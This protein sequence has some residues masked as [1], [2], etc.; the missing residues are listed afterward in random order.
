MFLTALKLGTLASRPVRGLQYHR[1][2]SLMRT[3]LGIGQFFY[4][5]S[6]VEI[7]F[8]DR[9]LSRSDQHFLGRPGNGNPSVSLVVEVEYPLYSLIQNLLLVLFVSL[10]RLVLLLLYAVLFMGPRY[11]AVLLRC[12]L[13]ILRGTFSAHLKE[14]NGTVRARAI[15]E[16]ERESTS[17]VGVK[18]DNET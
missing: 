1:A 12:S 17:R 3:L 10:T 7:P 6:E 14:A 16:R 15:R 2:K 8:V 18:S 11:P 5:H 4:R 13:A 9:K